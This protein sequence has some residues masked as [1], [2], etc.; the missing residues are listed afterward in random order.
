METKFKNAKL[1]AIRGKLGY[2]GMIIV[3]PV[4]RSGGLAFLWMD[5]RD[6]EIINYSLR[7]ISATIRLAGSNFSWKFTGFMATLTELCV[8]RHGSC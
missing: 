7:H 8:R 3:E 2:E 1:Q 5:T 4:G 6:V